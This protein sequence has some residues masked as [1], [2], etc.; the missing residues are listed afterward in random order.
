[1]AL[2]WWSYGIT[3]CIKI[4]IREVFFSA[5]VVVMGLFHCM[6]WNKVIPEEEFFFDYKI[7]I[8]LTSGFKK[9]ERDCCTA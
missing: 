4:L 1:L 6:Q 2:L 9:N 8:Y 5:E 3:K 7:D